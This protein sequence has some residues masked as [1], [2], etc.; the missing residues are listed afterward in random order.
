MPPTTMKRVCIKGRRLAGA[1]KGPS[2]KALRAA[3]ENAAS[4]NAAKKLTDSESRTQQMRYVIDVA[5]DSVVP[6]RAKGFAKRKRVQKVMELLERRINF[7]EQTERRYGDH[8]SFAKV[9]F[10]D[11]FKELGYAKGA[12]F[13]ANFFRIARRLSKLNKKFAKNQR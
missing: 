11:V 2:K 9:L 1:W 3:M 8:A 4:L 12:I 7:E 6:D 13:L 10:E 5:L